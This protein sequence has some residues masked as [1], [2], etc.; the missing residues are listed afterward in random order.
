LRTGLKKGINKTSK[1]I[2]AM[3]KNSYKI[4]GNN[5]IVGNNNTLNVGIEQN[6]K[7]LVSAIQTYSSSQE[8]TAELLKSVKIYSD[9]KSPISTRKIAYDIL[10]AFIN[11][12]P[13]ALPAFVLP[14][15]T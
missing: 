2:K 3:A 14:F 10:L 11:G 13:Q 8:E 1:S 4:K 5:V 15:P 6:L 9:K 12:I 7:E